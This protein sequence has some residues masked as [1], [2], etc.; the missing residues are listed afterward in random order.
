MAEAMDLSSSVLL[1]YDN[2]QYDET[3]CV[4]CKKGESVSERLV[5]MRSDGRIT[6]ARFSTL[7]GDDSLSQY[8]STVPTVV[9]VHKSCQRA[10]T[11]EN[12]V[13]SVSTESN[14]S[15]EKNLRSG[16]EKFDFHLSCVLCCRPVGKQ[17]TD[18]YRE[19]QS[20][21]KI[22]NT[23]LQICEDRKDIWGLEVV[24]RLHT[25]GDLRA[26]DARYHV[27]CYLY[28][29]SGRQKPLPG[30]P[31]TDFNA[32]GRPTDREMLG[33]FETVCEWMESGDCELFTIAQLHEKMVELA[34]D[35]EKVYGQ[36][37]IKKLLQKRYGDCIWFASICGK[38]DV[39][40]F[41]DMASRI[42]NDLWYVER[43]K[44]LD[45]ESERIVAAAAK[46]IKT[47]IKD[48][49]NNMEH[50][51]LNA[52]IS[53][54]S[55]AKDWVPSLLRLF[56][57][58]LISDEGK[59]I[60]IG[61]SIVQASR[62]KSVI[63]PVLFGVGVSLDHVLASKW[64]LTMLSRLGFSVT[65]DE[66]NRLKQSV[67]QAEDIEMPGSHPQFFTQ[68]S[69]DNVDHNVN[70]LNGLGSFH[71]MGIISMSV[72]CN[73]V[74]NTIDYG[75]FGETAI[76]R[77]PRVNVLKLTRGKTIPLVYFTAPNELIF[78]KIEVLECAQ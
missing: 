25:C 70:T 72:A 61:H 42:V 15:F 68:W 21:T 40:C 34:Y 78:V 51:P 73:S 75:S 5:A 3:S 52:N 44:D 69:A 66:V 9:C 71:G 49:D 29:S 74:L 77:L 63:S 13:C 6:L 33:V 46:L 38:R 27:K 20:K 41:R 47:Q 2:S 62:P 67:V 7:H 22:H 23:I 18:D 50:Y 35:P 39:I 65:P 60:G 45:K 30:M 1:D 55:K 8:L 54:Q 59:Q 10:Y 26:A 24:S 53:D 56:L 14:Q 11:K 12:N 36:K 64:L 19:V 31:S 28:F 4:I 76:R 48:L 16:V 57:G 58:H 37:Y 32:R 17:T 43:E